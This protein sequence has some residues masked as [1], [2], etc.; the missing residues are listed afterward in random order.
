MHTDSCYHNPM[1]CHEHPTPQKLTR[2]L[3]IAIGLN[4]AFVVAQVWY[5]LQAHSLALLADAG[6][7]FGDVLGLLLAAVAV[8]LGSRPARE[9]FTYGFQSATILAALA[10][11]LIMIWA[12]FE[13]SHEAIERLIAGVTMPNNQLIIA[14][15]ALGAVLNG[16]TAALLHKGHQHDLNIR[17]MYLHML[18]DAAVSVGVILTGVLIGL[19]G[20]AWIDPVVS[21]IIAAVILWGTWGLLKRALRLALQGVP[22]EL[23]TQKIKAYLVGRPGVKE[24]HDL[25]I[26]ALGTRRNALSVHLVMPGGH[27]GDAFIEETAHELQQMGIQ[28]ATLQVELG[29]A[30]HKCEHNCGA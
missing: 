29:N 2:T 21:L 4:A 20:K 27:P 6:H 5:G 14:V 1:H 7:N 9:G 13:I 12:A 30:P 23:E 8:W 11:A 28:H 26:W 3:W 24:V 22:T 15:A 19:T 25:H 16:V 10:N 17:G 18:S